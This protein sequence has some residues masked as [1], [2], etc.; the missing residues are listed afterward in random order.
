MCHTEIKKLN[1]ARNIAAA[2][3]LVMIKECLDGKILKEYTW[4]INKVGG[5]YQPVN[6]A[7]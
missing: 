7:T 1:R 6:A 4:L 3:K 2:D 5:A